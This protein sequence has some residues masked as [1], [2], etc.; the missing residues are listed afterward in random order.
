[1]EEAKATSMS[2][3]E[4]MELLKADAG[5]ND[6]PQS[7]V[8]DDKARCRRCDS[9]AA[10]QCTSCRAAWRTSLGMLKI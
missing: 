4:L 9:S 3:E 5:G 2:A 6:V 10:M 8:I 1:V 7:G